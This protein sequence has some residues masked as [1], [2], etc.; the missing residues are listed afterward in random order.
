MRLPNFLL[1][2]F[3]KC[4]TTSI[5]H[6][7]NQHPQ[8]YMSPVKEPNFLERD[9]N[10]FTGEKKSRIDTLDKYQNLFAQ[11]QDNHLSL[12]IFHSSDQKICS[13]YKNYRCSS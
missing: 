12:S 5:Y 7:L 3:E 9:W 4:G 11:V 6:Y 10:M 13:R 8:I 2:G 1:A